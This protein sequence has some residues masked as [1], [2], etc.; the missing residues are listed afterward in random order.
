[1]PLGPR[2]RPESPRLLTGWLGGGPVEHWH[3]E[4]DASA[5]QRGPLHPQDS[6]GGLDIA[7][8]IP[9]ARAEIIDGMGHDLPPRHLTRIIELIAGHAK[10]AEERAARS[11][12]A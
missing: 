3:V 1:W 2:P 4:H 8:T 10:A 6:S 9:G 7:A 5:A 11:R 12:A